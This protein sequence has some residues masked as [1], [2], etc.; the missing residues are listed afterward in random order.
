MIFIM[1][2]FVKFAAA[3]LVSAALFA[4]PA[5]ATDQTDLIASANQTVNNLKTDPAFAQAARMLHTAKAVLII[6]KLVKGG[7]IFG[8]EG[9]SGVLM[10]RSGRNWSQPAFFTLGSASF[11]LQIGL[12]QA[13][14]IFIIMSDRAL[15]GIV[16]GETK[17]GA[18]AGLTVVTLSAGAEGATTTH[19][20][21]MVVWTSGTGAYGG[22]TL[23]GSIIKPRKDWNSEYYGGDIGIMDILND[24]PTSTGAVTLRQNLSTVW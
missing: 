15:A 16:H 23:N 2:N 6:P 20:G 1:L 5:R 4:A 12:Q 8:A 18:G 13:Q 14:L 7:F 11:G 17:I 3:A 24:K 9:G 21:D 19:G 22:L 10:K